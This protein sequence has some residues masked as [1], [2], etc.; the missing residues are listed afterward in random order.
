[1][2]GT[3]NGK[4]ATQAVPFEPPLQLDSGIRLPL[5]FAVTRCY[6]DY[7][8]SHRRDSIRTGNGV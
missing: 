8:P 2:T 4:V 1:M 3:K 7:L 6:I 5:A